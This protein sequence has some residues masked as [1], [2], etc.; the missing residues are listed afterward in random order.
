MQ[1]H[2]RLSS[3][4]HLHN[5]ISTRTDNKPPITAPTNIANPFSPHSPV[6]HDVLRADPFLQTPEA[7]AGIVA[8]RDGFAAVFREAEGGDGGWVGEHGVSALAC[9]GCQ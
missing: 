6:G 9:E 3:R 2:D 1:H 7:N 8:S 4:K 5:P